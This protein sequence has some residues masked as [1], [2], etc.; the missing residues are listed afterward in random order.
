MTRKPGLRLPALLLGAVLLVAAGCSSSEFRYVAHSST[1]TYLKVPRAWTPYDSQLLDQAEA[2]AVEVAGEDAPS[3]VDQFFQGNLEWRM[4][5][6]ADPNPEPLHA[7]SY[8]DAPVVEVRVRD[9]TKDERDRVNLASLRNMF[10]PYDQLMAELDQERKEQPLAARP[11]T[12]SGFRSL[13]ENEIHL[14]NGTRGNRLQFELRQGDQFYII[15]QTALIDGKAE[16][17]YVLL[18]RAGERQFL[19]HNKILDEIANSFTVKQKG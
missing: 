8:A 18:I 3:F 2:K 17:V 7:V 5:F 12:S 19:E 13:G 4:A 16:H 14:A 15:D 1:R 6:D 11:P 9:L 10:F